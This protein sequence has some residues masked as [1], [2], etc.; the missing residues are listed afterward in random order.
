MLEF[1]SILLLSYKNMAS[2]L[3]ILLNCGEVSGVP[4]LFIKGDMKCYKWWQIVIVFFFFSWILF[5]PLSLKILFNMFM[6]DKIL[7]PKIILFLMLQFAA[8][9]NYLLSRNV[10]SVVL[11]GLEMYRDEK[12]FKRD[13]WR[14][15]PT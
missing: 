6:K 15:L 2:A 10:I 8:V 4:V 13:I 14:I 5:F 9:V 12:S 11:K 7:F 1:V 3:L